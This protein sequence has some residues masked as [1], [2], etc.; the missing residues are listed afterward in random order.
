M[1][2]PRAWKGQPTGIKPPG[3]ALSSLSFPKIT[4]TAVAVQLY[5]LNFFTSIRHVENRIGETLDFTHGDYF[6]GILDFGWNCNCNGW[7][8]DTWTMITVKLGPLLSS[9]FTRVFTHS[10]L[11]TGRVE[12]CAV[13]IGAFDRASLPGARVAWWNCNARVIKVLRE[14]EPARL[15]RLFNL[16]SR[17]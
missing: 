10:Q 6:T 11:V 8:Y 15:Q 16:L 3:T 4:A 13:V 17:F 5:G 14:R 9:E 1:A 7:N 12:Y 2:F